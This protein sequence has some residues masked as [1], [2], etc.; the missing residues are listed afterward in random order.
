MLDALLARPAVR[1][2][3]V[4]TTTITENNVASWALFEGFARRRGLRLSKEPLFTREVH[5][6]GAHDTEWQASIGPLSVDQEQSAK[7]TK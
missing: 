6:A 7:E 1:D 5:F 3:R 4:L 2:A